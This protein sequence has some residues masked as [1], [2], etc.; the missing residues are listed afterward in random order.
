MG[1]ITDIESLEWESVR[2]D[3]A[4]DV[5]GKPLL[6][7]EGIKMVLTKILPG[8]GFETHRDAYGHLLYFL[9]GSGIVGVGSEEFSIKPGLVVQVMAGEEHFYRNNS[10]KELTLISANITVE[11]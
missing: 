7:S 1:F 8:G 9:E 2:P 3:V 4:R 11:P 6:R 10:G 5:L